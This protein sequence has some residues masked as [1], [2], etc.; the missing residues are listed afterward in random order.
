[1]VAERVSFR[2]DVR[3]A[4]V[5]LLAA[6]RTDAEIDFNIYKARPR[7]VTIPHAF[8]DVIRETV[9]YVGPVQVQRD[10]TATVVVLHGLF[11]SA[12]AVQQ[13]DRFADDFLYWVSDDVHAAGANSTIA[14]ADIEDIPAYVADWLPESTP[15]T[16]FATQITLEG[17]VQS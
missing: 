3:A 13:A 17:F 10:L 6:Y 1:M 8:V 9:T 11:D 12:E 5:S 4:C 2:A 14:V 7:S 15:R 16:F